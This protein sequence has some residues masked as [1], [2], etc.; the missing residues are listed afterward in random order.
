[1][2]NSITQRLLRA[3][4][5][6]AALHLARG[7]LVSLGN[8]VVAGAHD[9]ERETFFSDLNKVMTV[10]EA[11]VSSQSSSGSTR[12][13]FCWYPPLQN[14]ESHELINTAIVLGNAAER[15]FPPHNSTTIRHR[16][17]HELAKEHVLSRFED[18]AFRDW[19]MRGLR[20]EQNVEWSSIKDLVV[21]P[22]ELHAAFSELTE[23]V[24]D[25]LHRNNIT[26]WATGG[27]L[28]GAM[29][30][31]G[32]AIP[33][34]D[35]VD[36]VVCPELHSNTDSAWQ[37]EA[38]V[39]AALSDQRNEHL[40]FWEPAPM[41]GWKVYALP[42]LYEKHLAR[43]GC[44]LATLQ[45]MCPFGIFVDLFA[46]RLGKQQKQ[47]RAELAFPDARDTWP[48]EWFGLDDDSTFPLKQLSDFGFHNDANRFLLPASLP[49]PLKPHDYIHRAFGKSALHECVIPRTQHGKCIGD[50]DLR[51]S[52]AHF[53]AQHA[54][55]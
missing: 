22:P 38:K 27:T 28:L 18:P 26:C 6:R 11:D 42:A 54:K 51:F 43:L 34:D 31:R 8:I 33:W 16:W 41:F 46:L 37:F 19:L 4:E 53:E 45:R 1:M 21:S 32:R 47:H 30:H 40:F 49:V 12:S 14:R 39:F 15:F 13:S 55:T 44:S 50:Q 35:D 5:R 23:T 36:L 3:A 52:L 48:R 7:L 29:R 25:V 24:V 20:G 2:D 10:A 9:N 17:Q